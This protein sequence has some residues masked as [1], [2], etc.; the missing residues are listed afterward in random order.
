MSNSPQGYKYKDVLYKVEGRVATVTINRPVKYNC[1]SV[2]TLG[3]IQDAVN[4]A[5]FDDRVAVIV[6]TG[7]G[8][9]AF[10]TGG[11]VSEYANVYTRAPHEYWKYMQIFRRTIE[12]ILRSSKPVIARLNGMAVGGGNEIQLACDLTFAGNHTFLGQVGTRVGSVACGGATQWLPI[13]VGAKKAVEMLYLNTRIPAKKAEE[14][15]LVNKVL[16]VVCHKSDFLDNPTPDQIEKAMTEKDDYKIDF[17]LLDK[18][19]M[20]VCVQ[21]AEKFPECLRYSKQQVNFWKELSWNMTVGHAA[22]WLS[23]HFTTVEPYEGMAAFTEKRK[24]DYAG[25]RNKLADGKSPEFLWGPYSKQCGKCS[26][27]GI[28]EEFDYCGVCSAKL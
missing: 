26:A 27:K 21:L 18:H 23:L 11:D 14:W 17:T 3:E 28:P 16:P 20:E 25:I 9:Y 6:L 8:K 22:D 24:P 15:G 1:Y 7:S 4:S 10:C 5:T 2:E 12:A 19:V 13:T